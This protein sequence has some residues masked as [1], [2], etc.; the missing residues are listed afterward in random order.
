MWSPNRWTTTEV[1]EALSFVACGK[2]K[3]FLDISS[4]TNKDNTDAE[5]IYQDLQARACAK[6]VHAIQD[7]STPLL[8]LIMLLDNIIMIVIA[9][10]LGTCPV[11]EARHW[12]RYCAWMIS[13][14]E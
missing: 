11:L 10:V 12:P 7:K 2:R 4:I 6:I 1:W 3:H 14:H 5:P 8:S 9:D 13:S